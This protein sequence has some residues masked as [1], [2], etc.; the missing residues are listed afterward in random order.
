MRKRF[1]IA[2]YMLSSETGIK[3]LLISFDIQFFDPE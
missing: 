1:P 3:M 2:N